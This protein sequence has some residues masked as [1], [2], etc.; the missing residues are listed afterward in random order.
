MTMCILE[1]GSY[2]N[3]SFSGQMW[4]KFRARYNNPEPKE[5][6]RYEALQSAWNEWVDAWVFGMESVTQD[7]YTRSEYQIHPVVTKQN[8]CIWTQDSDGTWNTSCSKTWEFIEGGPTDNE[9]HFC[10]HCGGSLLSESFSE[11]FATDETPG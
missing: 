2:D 11:D 7:E 4:E 1:Q 8:V 3:T 10:H 6:R 5:L 9:M